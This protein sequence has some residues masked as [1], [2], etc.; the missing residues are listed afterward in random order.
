MVQIKKKNDG[1][2]LGIT[3]GIATGKSTVAD[4]LKKSEIPLI[5]FDILSRKVVEPGKPAWKDII[6]FFG[7]SALNKD[8]SINRAYLRNIV[9]DD[10]IKLKKLETFI[11]PRIN[12]TFE[13]IINKYFKKNSNAIIQA[14]VPLLIEA[15]M[16]DMFDYIILVYL[17]Y[18]KQIKRLINR[19]KTSYKNAEKV[20]ASQ[21]PIEDKKKY[22]DFIID[23]SGSIE[24]TK[25]QVKSLIE[26]LIKKYDIIFKI[27]A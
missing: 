22:A 3:G 2:L 11:H 10:P 20:I 17:P 18:D 15:N 25:R 7:N 1:I 14:A 9:F 27:G 13:I 5:D 26:K 23:N 8:K 6:S 12:N 16:Q 19:D 21:M 24:N 4:M